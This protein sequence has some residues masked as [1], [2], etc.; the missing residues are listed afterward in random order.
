MVNKQDI[1]FTV[2]ELEWFSRISYNLGLRSIEEWNLATSIRIVS[3]CLKVFN[4]LFLLGN[5]TTDMVLSVL[6]AIPR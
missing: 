1:S 2:K 5:V 4:A 3:T 6:R